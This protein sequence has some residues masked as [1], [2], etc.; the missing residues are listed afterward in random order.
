MYGLSK[1]H[2]YPQT[3][4][5]HMFHLI[6]QSGTIPSF[7]SPYKFED[8]FQIFSFLKGDIIKRFLDSLGS[9]P[10]TENYKS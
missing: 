9:L 7:S 6:N 1:C 8:Q 2:T 5:P 10:N 4:T 3:E